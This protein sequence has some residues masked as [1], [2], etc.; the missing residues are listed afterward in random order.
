MDQVCLCLKVIVARLM[1]PGRVTVNEPLNQ[2]K[3]QGPNQ[4]I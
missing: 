2:T 1:M 3:L 4:K